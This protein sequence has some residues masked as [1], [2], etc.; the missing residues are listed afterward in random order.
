MPALLTSTRSARSARAT[1][2][3]QPVHLPFSD[4]VRLG[5]GP[6]RRRLVIGDH[7]PQRALATLA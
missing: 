7:G 1:G 3:D 5:N 6:R 4:N 2:L